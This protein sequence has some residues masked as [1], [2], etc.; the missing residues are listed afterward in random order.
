MAVGCFQEALLWLR[1]RGCEAL[2]K[3]ASVAVRRFQETLLKDASKRRFQEA[4][5][6]PDPLGRGGEY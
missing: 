2:P 4:L 3:G 5:P 1:F 6:A